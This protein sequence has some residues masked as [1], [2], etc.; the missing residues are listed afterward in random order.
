MVEFT[1]RFGFCIPSNKG[2]I[3]KE[4]WE[5]VRLRPGRGLVSKW[6]DFVEEILLDVKEGEG[7]GL[8]AGGPLRFSGSLVVIPT[9]KGPGSLIP[10]RTLGWHPN[11]LHLLLRLSRDFVDG[12]EVVSSQPTFVLALPLGSFGTIAR[13]FDLDSSIWSEGTGGWVR[14]RPLHA[15]LWRFCGPGLL[16]LL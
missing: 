14:E 16:A 7:V 13:G 2:F 12:L 5:K 1:K 15:M 4:L 11:H 8:L 10:M 9:Q 3:M 6:S